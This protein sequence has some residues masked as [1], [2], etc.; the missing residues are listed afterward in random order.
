MA[1]KGENIAPLDNAS[2]AEC[3][4]MLKNFIVAFE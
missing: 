2:R 1:G 3:A 4:T